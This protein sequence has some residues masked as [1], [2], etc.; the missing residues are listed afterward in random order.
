MSLDSG[1]NG[2]LDKGIGLIVEVVER[3]RF[4]R[5]PAALVAYAAFSGLAY[6][7]AWGV[8]L[9]FDWTPAEARTFALTLP[10]LLVVRLASDLFFKLSTGRWRFVSVGDAV[11]LGASTT[12]GSILFFALTRLVP[13]PV[14]VPATVV[15]LEWVFT[16]YVTAGVWVG[17]RMLFEQFRH[18][19]SGYN[20][21]ARRVLIVGAGEA[22]NMLAREMRRFPTGY[23]PVAFVDDDPNK[24]G[25]RLYG[26]EVLGTT[27]DLPKV[28]AAVNA[29]EVAIA[30]PSAGPK[31]LQKVVAACE[32]AGLP[33][34]V[35]PGIA[36]VLAGRVQV[37]QLRE[38]RIEDLLGR[39]PIDLDL[40]ELAS[41]LY[42]R[43]V[44]ITGAA[45]SIGSELARQVA[46]HAP[47]RIVLY[48]QAETELFFLESELRDRHPDAQIT[49]V[50]GDIVDAEGV[51]LLFSAY[52]PDRVFHAAAYKHVPV[53]ESNARE[54]VRNNVVGTLRIAE[55]A[56][57][58]G[59]GKVV[60]VSTDK[61][62]QP[63]SV[64]GATKRL[65][66]TLVLELNGRF[67]DTV[68]TAVRFGNVLGS[69]GSVIPI[70]EKQLRA[71]KPL[72]VTHPDATRYFMT[73]TEAVQLILQSSLLS[74]LGGNIG[75]L[76]MGEPIRV[77]D[78]AAN[79]LRLSGVPSRNGDSI[80]FTGLR[81]GEKLHEELTAPGEETRP[82]AVPQVRL[83]PMQGN[84][85]FPLLDYVQGWEE[86]VVGDDTAVIG[87]LVQL[88]P[89]LQADAAVGEQD[90]DVRAS[91]AFSRG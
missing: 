66:E 42:D 11:R 1:H 67:P 35:L 76:E 60:L 12:A 13:F 32:L 58:H 26:L 2:L 57:R 47:S 5:R 86:G 7:A 65:A 64:M 77:M 4:P 33:F 16:A 8:V 84:P 23:R 6:V 41:D 89:G 49:A 17:Y 56:G 37:T 88:F 43:C 21:S 72:T 45:G 38:I 91:V 62:A 85:D 3:V 40:R 18:Y 69:N 54:A 81:A 52:A 44:L 31:E 34:R 82:T 51:E 15:V 46:L 87:W 75:V 74:E 19:R 55:A 53:M 10:L 83:I 68:Y 78:L 79:M 50:V 9:G 20:G 59:S 90:G 25:T 39:K 29:V 63:V 30:I 28:A 71:G 14:T 61:A 80:V 22:G 24:L 36:E 48:D 70:F 27:H 73:I